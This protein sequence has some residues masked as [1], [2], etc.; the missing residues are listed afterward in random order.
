[1]VARSAPFQY[2]LD[3]ATGTITEVTEFGAGN[4]V[5]VSYTADYVVPSEYPQALNGSRDLDDQRGKWT[6]KPLVSGTYVGSLSA[7]RDLNFVL[8]T[9]TTAYRA[10]SPSATLPVLLGDAFELEPYTRIADATSCNSCHQ[11]LVYHGTYR[12][13]DTCILCHGAS[14]T[15]DLPRFVAANAPATPGQSVEFRTLVHKIHRGKELEDESY[16]VVGAGTAA[17]PD[18]FVAHAYHEHAT[19]PAYPDRTLACARCHGEGNTQALLPAEREHPTSQIRPLQIWRP[20]CATCHDGDP[21]TAHIDSNTAP[22]GGE[23]CAICHD[24]GEFEDAFIAHQ[25]LLEPR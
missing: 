22:N 3:P 5:L 16:Q 1:V 4:A 17:Y 18:N 19:L 24:P 7:A 2:T 15:E 12:G 21:V 9:A 6:G 25:E 13:F 8:G 20:A 10:S 11:D 23:A 14:G